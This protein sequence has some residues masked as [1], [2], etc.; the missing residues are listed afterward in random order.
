M[1]LRYAP[2]PDDIEDFIENGKWKCN[3]CGCCCAE[4]GWIGVETDDAGICTNLC[5][6]RRCKVYDSRPRECVV[7]SEAIDHVIQA[8]SCSWLRKMF[9]DKLIEGGF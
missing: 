5:Q 8:K 9:N 6:D 1:Y 3:E 4:A 2:L 7:M